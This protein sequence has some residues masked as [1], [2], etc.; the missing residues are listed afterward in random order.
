MSKLTIHATNNPTIIKL[1]SETF[2]VRGNYEYKNIDEAKSSPLAQQL[3]YLP[4]IK[5][6]YISGNFI[7]LERYSIV[8]WEDVQ[9]EVAEQISAYIAQGKPVVIEEETKKKLPV[10]LYIE[11]TPNPAVMKFVANKRLV[12][13]ICEFRS[14]D[15]A[16]NAPLA[17]ALFH[18]P[19][20]K[21]VFIDNNFV[22]VM[23]YEVANWDEILQ[24]LR[25]FIRDYIAEGKEIVSP[26]EEKIVQENQNLDEFSK[27]IVAI[28]DEYVRPAVASDGG[29]IQFIDY[30]ENTKQVR[31]LLQGACSG[32]PSS[33]MTLKN[34]IERMLHQLL[35]DPDLSVEA[36]NA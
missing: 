22:S 1:E 23:K 5:T 35:G 19:F 15:E 33:K 6:V 36:V 7:A 21:E 11:S 3:F 10:T 25:E 29:N 32:C 24:E 30:E 12:N 18:F 17:T 8:N 26:L 34:G 13:S 2:L 31:V 20:V 28:L 4:F 9:E 27:K 14:I 16:K